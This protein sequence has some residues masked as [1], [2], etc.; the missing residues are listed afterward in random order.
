[1]W[2]SF[3]FL[4]VFAEVNLLL[5]AELTTPCNSGN[6]AVH[7][8]H[9]VGETVPANSTMADVMSENATQ[10]MILLNRVKKKQSYLS[11]IRDSIFSRIKANAVEEYNNLNLTLK[12]SNGSEEEMNRFLHL[13][14]SNRTVNETIDWS[15]GGHSLLLSTCLPD[16]LHQRFKSRRKMVLHF[17]LTALTSAAASASSLRR[18]VELKL[19]FKRL[20]QHNR[21]NINNETGVRDIVVTIHQIPLFPIES[22]SSR[23]RRIFLAETR[24]SPE[25]EGWISFDVTHFYANRRYVTYNFATEVKALD[26]DDRALDVEQLIEKEN[27]PSR[28]LHSAQ[29]GM[30]PR[31]EIRIEILTSTPPSL[32]TGVPAEG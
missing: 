12:S 26:L 16:Q 29:T 13:M 20:M 4:L 25:Y 19:F 17:P 30:E 32:T 14:T 10:S 1:M 27:C 21:S 2:P 24:V 6:C 7:H 11:F 5:T 31:L 18:S 8:G 28:G 15:K 22:N 3:F 23:G 9:E